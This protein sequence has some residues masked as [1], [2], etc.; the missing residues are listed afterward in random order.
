M[1]KFCQFDKISSCIWVFAYRQLCHWLLC[2]KFEDDVASGSF[3]A[4]QIASQEPLDHKNKNV[5][6]H[7][8]H[9]TA[10]KGY[11]TRNSH[12]CTMVFPP[13]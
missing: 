5:H 7:Y 4:E 11:C 6:E 12:T 1:L 2:S 10:H 9:V 3:E 13:V 8:A